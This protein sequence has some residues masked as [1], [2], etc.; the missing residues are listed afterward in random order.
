MHTS[1]SACRSPLQTVGSQRLHCSIS[2]PFFPLWS[3][4]YLGRSCSHLSHQPLPSCFFSHTL[5]LS[6][7]RCH[8]SSPVF[9]SLALCSFILFQ[10][11][12][13]NASFF[14]LLHLTLFSISPS[15]SCFTPLTLSLSSKLFSPLWKQWVYSAGLAC[16][17][18]P[19]NPPLP[20]P[21]STTLLFQLCT[22]LP[23][24]LSSAL[25]PTPFPLRC[26]CLQSVCQSECEVACVWRSL[27][28]CLS[29]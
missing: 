22:N 4:L 5:T 10:L 19:P 15:F 29:L 18:L 8:S 28:L 13:S 26:D 23:P 14:Y 20:L 9:S 7:P 27:I 21:P 6:T 1:A 25:A 24:P 16:F 3:I 12:T 11:L 2:L 17:N